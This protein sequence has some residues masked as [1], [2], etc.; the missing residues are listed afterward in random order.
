MRYFFNVTDGHGVTI[1]MDGSE[2]DGP[3]TARR[4]AEKDIRLLLADGDVR[5]LCRRHWRMDVVDEA[6]SPVFKLP[7]GH[8]L[9]A[10]LL[11]SVGLRAA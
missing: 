9:Q 1:D 6:G 5:G 2:L 8:A 3:E 7:F 10:D 4:E 11:P